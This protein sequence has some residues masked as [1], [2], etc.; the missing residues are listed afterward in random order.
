MSNFQWSCP[1]LE[2]FL[3]LFKPFWAFTSYSLRLWKFKAPFLIEVVYLLKFL[4]FFALSLYLSLRLFSFLSKLLPKNPFFLS[5]LL[6]SNSFRLFIFILLKI[7]LFFQ[8][9]W[10]FK[11]FLLT[12]MKIEQFRNQTRDLRLKLAIFLNIFD[13]YLGICQRFMHFFEISK[14]PFVGGQNVGKSNHFHVV[15]DIG[16]EFGDFSL[17]I[18]QFPL[19]LGKSL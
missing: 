10:L 18:L 6:K 13:N 16:V 2:L 1:F 15:D 8:I 17:V 3:L 19:T 4:L 14:S 7:P 5:K 11:K 12:Y 9:F